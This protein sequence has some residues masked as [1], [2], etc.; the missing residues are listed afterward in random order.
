MKKKSLLLIMLSLVMALKACAWPAFIV[1]THSPTPT[2]TLPPLPSAT[3]TQAPTATP[4]PTST[5][6]PTTR[7]NDGSYALL[8][9]DYEKGLAEYQTALDA[10]TDP[11]IQAAARLGIGQ[12]KYLTGDYASALNAFQSLAEQGSPNDIRARALYFIG[13]IYT[14]Q[15]QYKE[16]DSAFAG[17]LQ[18]N[19]GI[20]DAY[21]QELR[22]DVLINAGDFAGG[23]NAYQAAIQAPHL[24]SLEA[25]QIKIAQ[26][27][28]SQG[29]LT[30]ALTQ[31]NDLYKTTS[32]DYTKAT[33]DLLIGQIQISL[34]H[35]D[36][37][38]NNFQDAV[39]N[40]PRSYDSYSAL[41][42]LVNASVTV[43][44]FN[45]GLVDYFAGKYALAGAAFDRYLAANPNPANG[46]VYYYKALAVRSLGE[47]QYPL[48]SS[49]RTTAN[50]QAG[51][52]DDQAAIA[53]LKT[54]IDHFPTD[55]YYQDAWDE[56]A[57]TQWAYMDHPTDAA[58][59]MLA[60][61][62]ANPTDPKAPDY[63]FQAGRYFERT[64]QLQDAVQV[65]TRIA[66]EYAS[67]DQ[68]FQ[69]LLFAGVSLVRLGDLKNA[70]TTFQRALLLDTDPVHQSAAYLWIGKVQ[71]AQND[72]NGAQASWQEALQKDPTGYYSERARDLILN[73]KAFSSPA[74]VDLA[75]NLP[76]ERQDAETWVRTTFN[77]P[78]NT[79]LSSPGPLASDPRLMRAIEFWSLGLYTEADVEI[80]DF[81]QAISADPAAS[82]SLIQV[83]VDM[84]DYQNAI[85]ASRQ[86]LT[87]ANMNDVTSLNAPVYF[88]HVR[89]GLYYKDL[90]LPAAQAED[91]DPLLL[92]SLMRQESLFEGF[93][94]SSAG[95]RGLMQIM[96]DTGKHLAATLGWPDAY[97]DSDLYRPAVNIRLGAH[98]LAQ[99]VQGFEGNLYVTLAA[100]NGG[101]GNAL[102]W[103]SLAPDDLDLFLEV[104]RIQE[105]RTYIM[106]IAELYNIYRRLYGR[107]P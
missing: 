17:Y 60:F 61:V 18:L 54:L 27:N 8:E 30:T 1:P 62:N 42:A 21:I 3:P 33:M 101:P 97:S 69:G 93:I 22:G 11:A 46:T 99:Q 40:F 100:Y 81:R 15:K 39:N 32:S 31:F 45:R 77:L 92:F 71:N 96:P 107:T 25:L 16:A 57:F 65:W 6:A 47:D 88:N 90:V 38:H 70:Q 53:E 44:D 95:A 94:Q 76:M 72:L 82:F 67:S 14:L 59:T 63:L 20:I 12:V 83:L 52:P 48:G 9:G 85:I 35:V 29:D 104:I 2:A 103:K 24:G 66:D 86:V 34:G 64:S 74:M 19:P 55:R 102:I 58:Q 43:D 10:S 75:I 56:I 7:L 41:V 28:L 23:I 79:D 84:G 4:I 51:L 87:L 98:Y 105:T 106:N 73:R 68:T 89:F 13:K 91:L 37:A 26:A 50:A 49:A 5:P 80:T 78:A 36:E